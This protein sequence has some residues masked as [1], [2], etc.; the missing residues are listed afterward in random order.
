MTRDAWRLLSEG[1]MVINLDT[2][3]VFK[4]GSNGLLCSKYVDNGELEFKSCGIID[5][6]GTWVEY[7]DAIESKKKQ[8]VDLFNDLDTLRVF[9][10]LE[11]SVI[12]EALRSARHRWTCRGE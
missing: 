8:F 11:R 9:N 7:N 2:K 10:P 1:K 5:T 3:T 4:N 12:G 6:K